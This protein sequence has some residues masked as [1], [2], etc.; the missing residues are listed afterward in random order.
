MGPSASSAPR[1]SIT[2]SMPG[3]KAGFPRWGHEAHRNASPLKHCTGGRFG[4]AA[5]K[6]G[7]TLCRLTLPHADVKLCSCSSV[8]AALSA[9]ASAS[10]RPQEQ[11]AQA[12]GL[13]EQ[14]P[15]ALMASSALSS[16]SNASSSTSSAD[17]STTPHA[18]APAPLPGSGAAPVSTA[19][20]VATR[21]V[22]P[23]VD[24]V[25]VTSKPEIMS[26]SDTSSA[27][28]E[29]A[30]LC[31]YWPPGKRSSLIVPRCLSW[32]RSQA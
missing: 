9:L 27:G 11:L 4:R 30:S 5:G 3:T 15:E 8:N 10:A 14:S 26:S 1:S 32:L 13:V 6:Q 2:P 28:R 24:E 19:G 29:E 22:A 12:R 20:S 31:V 18:L 23:S 25:L 17:A 7:K 21:T 16:A